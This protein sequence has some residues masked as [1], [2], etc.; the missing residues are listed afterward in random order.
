MEIQNIHYTP[1]WHDRL[2]AFMKS[3]Y[4][5]R[6][7]RYLN[8]WIMNMD[9]SDADCRKKCLLI[10][11]DDTIIGCTTVNKT[12]IVNQ[13]FIE[14]FF[15]RGNTIISPNQRGKGISKEI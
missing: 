13:N 15:F 7:S 3:V 8:W 6:N 12:S 10:L 11:E 14:T 1:E 4:P 5:H 9:H 2:L